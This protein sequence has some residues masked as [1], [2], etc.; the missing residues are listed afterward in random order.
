M[1]EEHRRRAAEWF[2]TVREIGIDHA[3]ATAAPV[4]EKP[5][6]AT[7]DAPDGPPLYD[8]GLDSSEGLWLRAGWAGRG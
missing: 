2:L 6:P 4:P 8:T 7:N 5:R 1:S 3:V